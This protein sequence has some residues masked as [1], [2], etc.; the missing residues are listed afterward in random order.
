MP[1][2]A[3]ASSHCTVDGFV[4]VI[5]ESVR[6]VKHDGATAASVQPLVLQMIGASASAGASLGTALASSIERLVRPLVVVVVVAFGPFGGCRSIESN[7]VCLG[8]N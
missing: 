1:C 2:D 7:P 8:L 4:Q 6:K 3:M 5:A